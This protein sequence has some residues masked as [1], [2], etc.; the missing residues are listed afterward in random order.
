MAQDNRNRDRQD[1][2]ND[3]ASNPAADETRQQGRSGQTD[4]ESATANRPDRSPDLDSDDTDEMDDEDRDD[5]MRDDGSPN[6]RR[7]IG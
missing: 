3:A 6:R 2:N 4:Q 1:W 7:N 5:D